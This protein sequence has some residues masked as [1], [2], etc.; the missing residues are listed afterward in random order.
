MSEQLGLRMIK[1]PFI[2]CTRPALEAAEYAKEH[3]GF[4]QFHVGVFKAYLEDGENIGHR[5]VLCDIA[6]KSGLD[7]DE[8][9]RAL[10]EGWYAERIDMQNAEAR[11]MGISVIP[12]YII[13][14]HLIEGA[15][16]YEIFQ[17]AMTS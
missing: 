10:D 11:E 3:G 5:S 15:R 16:P 4:E 6:E 2:A 1:P 9:E 8:M 14:R 12:T 17:R 13:G 7:A